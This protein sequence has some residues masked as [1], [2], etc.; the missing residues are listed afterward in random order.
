MIL[1]WKLKVKPNKPVQIKKGQLR[2]WDGS[3]SG[4]RSMKIQIDRSPIDLLK[5]MMR[6]SCDTPNKDNL[7]YFTIRDNRFDS[8]EY[9]TEW[10]GIKIDVALSE[11]KE[12]IFSFHQQAIYTN[13]RRKKA[14]NDSIEY[15]LSE[16]ATSL[17]ES[18]QTFCGISRVEAE[19]EGL[20]I[21][22]KEPPK[23]PKAYC[24]DIEEAT[25]QYEPL[26]IYLH[27][28]YEK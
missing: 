17:V 1:S 28:I 7:H 9:D 10:S 13:E 20:S 26:T 27:R 4:N 2:S 23:Y 25:D 5:K 18:L 24:F 22:S 16:N 11:T 6:Q 15:P 8:E 3:L 19:S 21:S 14:E 12:N